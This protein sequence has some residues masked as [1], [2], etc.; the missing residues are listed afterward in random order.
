MNNK[1]KL[2][3][4]MTEEINKKYPEWFD[5]TRSEWALNE[6][7]TRY[8]KQKFRD[9]IIIDRKTFK[10]QLEVDYYSPYCGYEFSPHAM[11][12][13]SLSARQFYDELTIDSIGIDVI[14]DRVKEGFIY[15]LEECDF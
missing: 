1:E 15:K 10:E 4:E 8:L 7:I 14:K 12:V 11:F 5:I 6:C 13:V 9:L 2:I 3:E